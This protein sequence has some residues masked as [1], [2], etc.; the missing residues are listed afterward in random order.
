M[1]F[2]WLEIL[3]K[4]FEVA[5]IPLLGA[6]TLYLITLIDA[7]KKELKDKAKSETTKKYIEMLDDTIINC[8]IATNQTYVEA[9]KKAGSFDAEAQKQAFK[10][11]YEAVMAILTDDAQVYLNEAIKDL[12]AYITNKIESGVAVAKQQPTA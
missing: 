1:Q 11:T 6:A 12:N 8:V 3:Y 5:I 9:L 2:D 4:I 7:K 10:L